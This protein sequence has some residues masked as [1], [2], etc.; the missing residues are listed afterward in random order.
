M[1]AKRVLAAVDFGKGTGLAL[2]TAFDMAIR[3]GGEVIP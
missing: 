2:E 1:G 3:M